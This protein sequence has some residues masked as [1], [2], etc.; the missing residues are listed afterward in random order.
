MQFAQLLPEHNAYVLIMQG[1][2]ALPMEKGSSP[3]KRRR[4]ERLAA[5]FET[6]AKASEVA[7]EINTP[8]TYFSAILAGDRGL[9][10][11]VA[12]KIERAYGLD[13]GWFDADTDSRDWPFSQELYGAVKEL[14]P[15]VLNRLENVIRATLGM[16]PKAISDEERVALFSAIQQPGLP[17]KAVEERIPATKARKLATGWLPDVQEDAHEESYDVR[18]VPDKTN[19]RPPGRGRQAS[20]KR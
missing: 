17:D 19:E 13:E 7:Q 16:N 20:G 10:D 2:Y 3:R 14:G 11:V 8:A 1:A 4:R 9:G 5:F 18:G 6:V 15:G 12:A